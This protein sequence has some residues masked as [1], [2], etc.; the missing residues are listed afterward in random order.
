MFSKAPF[1]KSV[2]EDADMKKEHNSNL[3]VDK[4]ILWSKPEPL[5]LNY[6]EWAAL[7][8]TNTFFLHVH[9]N[10]SVDDEGV[11]VERRLNI[12]TRKSKQQPKLHFNLLL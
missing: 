7:V 4:N 11:F 1:F 5:G 10:T 9:S 6:R 3:K 8:P 2:H 12:Q